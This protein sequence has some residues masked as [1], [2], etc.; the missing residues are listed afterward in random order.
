MHACLTVVQVNNAPCSTCG[1]SSTSSAGMA[2]PTA[3]ERPHAG[4]V[5]LYNCEVCGEVGSS[6]T[7][8][9]QQP[10]TGT[11]AGL[12][13]CTLSVKA[14]TTKTNLPLSGHEVPAL[15]RPSQAIGLPKRQ[16][17]RFGMGD[18]GPDRAEHLNV[19]AATNGAAIAYA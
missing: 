7:L 17:R 13:C 19:S 3:A 8:V 11:C 4:R 15:Q 10:C 2:A 14:L 12:D 18:M 16:V 5:E 1:S 6:N 9:V